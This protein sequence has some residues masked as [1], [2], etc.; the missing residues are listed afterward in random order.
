MIRFN[1]VDQIVEVYNGTIWAGVAGIRGGITIA[2]AEDQG[3][4]SALIF[5]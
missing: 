3:V 2:E 1:T 4:I 5:G